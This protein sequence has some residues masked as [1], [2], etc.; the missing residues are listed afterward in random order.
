MYDYLLISILSSHILTLNFVVV[1]STC[2]VKYRS[3]D[4]FNLKHEYLSVFKATYNRAEAEYLWR[5]VDESAIQKLEKRMKVI[6]I[7]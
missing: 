5:E 3:Y 4:T 1:I 2:K 7:Y 6:S